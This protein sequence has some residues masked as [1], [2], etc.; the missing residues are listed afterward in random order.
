MSEYI[1]VKDLTVAYDLK[2]VLWDIDLNYPKGS[3]IAIVGPNGA[4][5]STL[6]KAML[7]LLKT[8]SG[9][10]SFNNKTLKEMQKEIA[11][12]PQRG[13]VDWDFPTTVFDV[14]LM[15][16]YGQV[17]W[18]KKVTKKDRDLA[19]EAIKKVGMENFLNRQISELSGGQQQRVFLARALVQDASIYFMDEPFQGVDIKTEQAIIEILKDLK[20]QGKTVIVVHH[21]LST[22]ESYFDFVTLINMQVIANGKVSEVFTKENIDLTYQINKLNLLMEE[23]HV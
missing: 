22:V 19:L 1:K 21:D 9:N 13:S 2:P 15:G 7:N 11:Y 6:I 17:G 23:N 12:V 10:I 5:K 8:V 14:V 16:R 20:N 18:F 3:L 4:G